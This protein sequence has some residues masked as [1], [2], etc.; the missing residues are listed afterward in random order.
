M[1]LPVRNKFIISVIAIIFIFF[2]LVP[3]CS[4]TS[5]LVIGVDYQNNTNSSTK[6]VYNHLTS[7]KALDAG[8]QLFVNTTGSTTKLLEATDN[9]NNDTGT[10]NQ[11]FQSINTTEDLL[12]NLDRVNPCGWNSLTNFEKRTLIILIDEKVKNEDIKVV[13][14]N[15]LV[16]QPLTIRETLRLKCLHLF[17]WDCLDARVRQLPDTTAPAGYKCPSCLLPELEQKIKNIPTPPNQNLVSSVIH[18][19]N[20]NPN[21]GNNN[22]YL[23]EMQISNNVFT[24]RSKL[25]PES[26]NNS[27]SGG[28]SSIYIGNEDDSKYAKRA[29]SEHGIRYRYT[30][31][32]QVGGENNLNNLPGFDDPHANPNVKVG[33]NNGD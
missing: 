23:N 4:S 31:L 15:I 20:S 28:S 5:G 33:E 22:D 10:F 9:Y 30:R 12:I 6:G 24:A 8:V 25:L 21:S 26:N 19:E 13:S 32:P 3:K 14:D 1:F 7:S 29:A 17:H 2:W 16:P 27:N 18:N 11:T